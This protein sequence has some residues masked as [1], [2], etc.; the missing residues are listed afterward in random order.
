M[1][2]FDRLFGK[3]KDSK[4]KTIKKSNK[5]T[6]KKLKPTEN[7]KIISVE[8]K[9]RGGKVSKSELKRFVNQTVFETFMS[10]N[11]HHFNTPTRTGHYGDD[12]YLSKGG[13]I[14]LHYFNRHTNGTPPFTIGI[15]IYNNDTQDW[16]SFGPRNYITGNF[17][18]NS[19]DKKLF[20]EIEKIKSIH[21]RVSKTTPDTIEKEKK[22]LEEEEKKRLEKL[23]NEVTTILKEFDKDNNGVIDIIEDDP[24]KKLLQKHQKLII[25]IDKSYIQ[26]FV[27]ISSFLNDKKNNIQST[28]KSLKKVSNLKEL[29]TFVKILKNQKHTY[30]VL[31]FHSISMI[32]SLT[33]EE[34][35]LITFYEIYEHFDK[36]KIFQ[37]DHEKEVS[38]ELKQLNFK[39]SQVIE[40]LGDI[41]YRI[42]SFEN[43]M[44]ESL[45]ELSYTTQNGFDNL[46]GSITSELKSINSSIG[47]NNLLTGIQTYQMYKIN[48]NT[49]SLN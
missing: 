37:S 49:K 2:I 40:K 5:K 11:S 4:K 31:L 14:K 45:N 48:K 27:K 44:I 6:I 1:G 7:Y 26:H 23:N 29:K 39:T 47:L 38:K 43:S 8:L 34:Q 17:L 18:V 12:Q 36:L 24:F 32:T 35:D 13:C 10:V 21:S 15:L 33:K 3:K 19:T 42:N 16:E 9:S 30:N 28:F 46:R 22:R 41:M 25:T 20:T